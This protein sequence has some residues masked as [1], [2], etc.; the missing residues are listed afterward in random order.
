MDKKWGKKKSPECKN[1]TSK[2]GVPVDPNVQVMHSKGK[3]KNMDMI[4][5][6]GLPPLMN[7][8]KGKKGPKAV[9]INFQQQYAA[10]IRK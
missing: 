9:P 8:T 6:G 2:Y 10:L 4:Q 1:C 5:V 7:I 3:N